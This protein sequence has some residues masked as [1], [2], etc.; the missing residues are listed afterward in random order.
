MHAQEIDKA[1]SNVSLLSAYGKYLLPVLTFRDIVLVRGQGCYVWDASGNKY[2]DLNSGQ[3]CSILGHSNPGV[4]RRMVEIC[5][6]LQHTD[7]S[8][9]SAPVLQAARK[10]H[11][12]AP[13]MNARTIFL[14]TGAEAVECC[15][16]YAKHIKE[17][18]GIISFD[19][20]YHGL[21]HGTAAY[22]LSRDK[23]RPPVDYSYE[24]PAP[25]VYGDADDAPEIERCIERFREIV[26]S[27]R[28][29]IAAAIFEPIISGGGFFFPPRRYF[30]AIRKICDDNDIFLIF[31][32]CQTGFGRT[33]SWF[34]YQQLECIPDFVVCAKAMGLGYPVSCVIVNGNTIAHVKFAMEYFSSHQN[35]AFAGALVSYLIDEIH[36]GDLLTINKHS[37]ATLLATLTSL[38][39]EFPVIKNPRGKGLM[40]A[41]DL[42]TP[43]AADSKKAGD[44][45]CRIA[46]D[47]G[48]LMQHCNFG[49]TIRLLP[50]YVA[51][52]DDFNFFSAQLEKTL[53]H[54]Q[55]S[56]T[57]SL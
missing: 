9:L 1:E 35:E 48:L 31:D 49:K 44:Y 22:S 15:L 40:C 24:T 51:E 33:G 43:G 37:G 11:D 17:R 52:K 45:F 21:T 8:T 26:A 57:P 6:T 46:Q 13:E 14:S 29:N 20:G 23:I 39:R 32:E 42:D 53:S 47:N 55:A 2:L 41:F 19:R 34:Y 38:A 25:L 7:T 4:A 27:D 54:F 30:K 50:S 36:A 18:P 12:C 16:K 56:L 5:Q 3:F 28:E 10:I